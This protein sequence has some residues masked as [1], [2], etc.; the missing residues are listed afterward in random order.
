MLTWLVQISISSSASKII[1]FFLKVLVFMLKKFLTIILCSIVLSLS[2]EFVVL[3]TILY[4]S[5][6]LSIDSLCRLLG[7]VNKFSIIRSYFFFIFSLL[8]VSL[9]VIDREKLLKYRYLVALIVFLCLVSGKFTG[10]SLGFYDYL[11]TDNTVEYS[12]STLLGIPRGIR[13]D[14][15]ATE[16]PMYFA[17]AL[18]KNPFQYFNEKLGFEGYDMVVSG[19]SPIKDVLILTRPDLWGFLFLSKDYAFSFYWNLRLLLLFMSVFEFIYFFGKKDGYIAFLSAVIVVF[20][21]PVQWWLSQSL[22][23]MIYSALFFLVCYMK[24][25]ER[26]GLCKRKIFLFVCMV[27]FS[28]IYIY[29]LF[30][31]R[32]KFH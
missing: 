25:F 8:I 23:I 16:K 32:Y 26:E 2:I 3:K 15:W 4:V 18:S 9:R 13:G 20:S 14:E 21:P 6:L 29:L 24:F 31:P 7:N 11:I 10:S 27:F 28:N 22:M 1:L 19:F 5:Q 30:I 17:Q 12:C